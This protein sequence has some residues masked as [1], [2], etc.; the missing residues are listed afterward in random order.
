M[1]PVAGDWDGDGTDTVGLYSP[2][3]GI[4]YLKNSHGPGKP[5]LKVRF[6]PRKKQGIWPVAGDWDGDN[7][8]E[9]GFYNVRNRTFVAASNTSRAPEKRVRR[10]GPRNARVLPLAGDWDDS[11]GSPDRRLTIEGEWKPSGGL[12]RPGNSG[13]NQRFKDNPRYQLTVD[14][15]SWLRIKLEDPDTPALTDPYLY[16]LNPSNW[17]VAEDNDSG[18][19]K[20]PLRRNAEIEIKLFKGHYVLVAA[21]SKIGRSGRFRITVSGRSVSSLKER[22]YDPPED[23]DRFLTFLSGPTESKETA[24]AYY[25]AVD[26]CNART[27]LADWVQLAETRNSGNRRLSESFGRPLQSDPHF[28]GFVV[29]AYRNGIDL[30]LGRRMYTQQFRTPDGKTNV[31]SFVENYPTQEHATRRVGKIATVA[32]E[33]SLPELGCSLG[34][35]VVDELE[36]RY[37]KFFIFDANDERIGSIDLDFRGDKFVPGVCNVCH[38]GRPK[39]LLR[40]GAY[41]DHGDTG[42]L[43][44]PWDVTQLRFPFGK[45]FLRKQQTAEFDFFDSAALATIPE[46]ITNGGYG[47]E[48]HYRNLLQ[49]W[50][51]DGYEHVPEGWRGDVELYTK[52]IAPLCRACHLQRFT[53]TSDELTFPTEQSFKNANM[54]DRIKR[55]VF[56]EGK[57]P[58][59]RLTYE[60]FWR[61]FES[62]NYAAGPARGPPGCGFEPDPARLAD[63]Q[64]PETRA[65]QSDHDQARRETQPQSGQ[66]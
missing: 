11:D 5:N 15:E 46:S 35:P 57:M 49:G 4:F 42:A 9:I 1:L 61:Q 41:P 34:S 45:P 18:R 48:S 17:V 62:G 63:R 22:A 20:L 26:P 53:G 12:M 2:S 23:P 47:T 28:R 65:S 37:T 30:G 31:Y 38:G 8:D 59:A 58:A 16:L 33:Y 56:E 21:T 43:F 10:F 44:M 64:G 40:S 60:S 19:E 39:A 14:E 52:V 66:L 24:A 3:T 6:G 27:T 55:L 25:A 36:S 54:A 13:Y 7:D 29:G 51:N 32:M 50:R